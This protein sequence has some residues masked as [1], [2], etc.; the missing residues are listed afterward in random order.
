[1]T[2]PDLY[3]AAVDP[4]KI[5]NLGDLK[6]TNVPDN[7]SII[8]VSDLR[9]VRTHSAGLLCY[10]LLKVASKNKLQEIRVFNGN[11]LQL[12][13]IF[14]IIKELFEKCCL[15]HKK[16]SVWYSIDGHG[17][18]S[19]TAADE[20][21]SHLMKHRLDKITVSP[22]EI[23]DVNGDDIMEAKF[24]VV[25]TS[26]LSSFIYHVVDLIDCEE[27]YKFSQYYRW[28]DEDG[29]PYCG[30][31]SIRDFRT[32][33]PN[34]DGDEEEP[35]DWLRDMEHKEEVRAL[36]LSQSVIGDSSLKGVLKQC[37]RFPNLT[38]LDLS[39]NPFTTESIGL[40]FEY[41][42]NNNNLRF[43][44]ITYTDPMASYPEDPDNLIAYCEQKGRV[45][46]VE[47]I[48]WYGI[49][50]EVITGRLRDSLPDKYKERCVA[51]HLLYSLVDKLLGHIQER[52]DIRKELN[53]ILA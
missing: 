44:N 5:V 42:Q 4:E 25:E 46:L 33:V 30:L 43:L 11:N 28:K 34:F 35:V 13:N 48:I 52:Q 38:L 15:H 53:K 37:S 39:F 3:T 45:D 16:L 24:K 26:T 10:K 18:L 29:V 21:M 8:F 32:F 40:I 41:L 6:I 7:N 49:A 2:T 9:N 12:T 17:T 31:H 27:D 50:E 19:Q 47:K 1:L 20:E 22:N 51:S 36:D 23:I 14:P